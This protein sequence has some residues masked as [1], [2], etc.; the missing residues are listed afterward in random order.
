MTKPHHH[1]HI[2]HMK[3]ASIVTM[4]L[5]GCVVAF[6]F[7]SFAARQ[8][9][10]RVQY[11]INTFL[12]YIQKKNISYKTLNA[13][14]DNTCAKTVPALL[15]HGIV[16]RSTLGDGRF[17]LSKATFAEHMVALKENGYTTI[18]LKDMQDFLEKG[19]CLKPKSVL[20]T[21]DDGKKDSFYNGDPILEQLGFHAVMFIATGQSL[22]EESFDSTYYLNAIEIEKMKETG[23]W[24]IGSHMVQKEGGFISIDAKGTQAQFLSSKQWIKKE[25]RLETEQEFE[26]RVANELITSKNTIQEKLHQPVLF[27]SYPFSDYG[28]DSMNATNTAQSFIKKKVA[29]NYTYAFIQQWP[30]ESGFIGNSPEDDRHLLRRIEPARTWTGDYLLHF[31]ER[32]TDIPELTKKAQDLMGRARFVSPRDLKSDTGGILFTPSQ[33]KSSLLIF[34]GTRALTDYTFNVTLDSSKPLPVFAVQA[35]MKINEDLEAVGCFWMKNKISI[36]TTTDKTT[37]EI[38]AQPLPERKDGIQPERFGISVTGNEVVCLENDTPVAFTVLTTAPNVG[39][40][41]VQVWKNETGESPSLLVKKAEISEAVPL[42]DEEKENLQSVGEVKGEKIKVTVIDKKVTTEEL[43]ELYNDASHKERPVQKPYLND[44]NFVDIY[45]QTREDYYGYSG[46]HS[47]YYGK[48]SAT[49]KKDGTTLSVIV[50]D[51]LNGEASWVMPEFPVTPGEEY[52][53]SGKYVSNASLIIQ[54]FNKTKNGTTFW[55]ELDELPVSTSSTHYKVTFDVPKDVTSFTLYVSIDQL[56]AYQLEQPAIHKLKSFD[57]GYVTLSFDDGYSTYKDNALPILNK[58]GYKS[59]LAVISGMVGFPRYLTKDDLD[60]IYRE[61]NEIAVHTRSH[62]HFSVIETYE[63]ILKEI[64]GSW[65]DLNK[66]GYTPTSFVFPYGDYTPEAKQMTGNFFQAVRTSKRGFN[67]KGSDPTLLKDQIIET[68]T[69]PEQIDEFIKETK[70]NHYWL[71]LE[72][73]DVFPEKDPKNPESI[74][75]AQL[76]MLLQKIHDS[77]LKVITIREGVQKILAR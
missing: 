2:H 4:A 11:D 75:N 17:T 29:E 35:R 23:R 60:E 51:Y 61:G 33:N 69:T 12:S 27:V 50:W 59:T 7:N 73:H 46:L 19:K 21:F 74:T 49:F 71:I 56:G 16:D 6:I 40:V 67:T 58:Y 66:A 13:L 41:G 44:L 57:Q 45:S 54:S 72:L 43:Q 34:D 18:T 15:Y 64:V 24:E 47:E 9:M 8:F 14:V 38:T 63:E 28:Q 31:F 26:T 65:Y 25:E 32:G 48:T 53:F 10:F 20:L 76:E 39:G 77:G 1:R 70:D 30:Y 37:S 68:D 62:G 52:E 3:R 55:R 42:S 22:T 36:R 5:I